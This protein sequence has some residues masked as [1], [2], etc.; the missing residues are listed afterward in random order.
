MI[1]FL[2]HKQIYN[3]KLPLMKIRQTSQ[4]EKFPNLKFCIYQRYT[5]RMKLAKKNITQHQSRQNPK[6]PLIMVK[7]SR[8]K[9]IFQN[10]GCGTSQN[11]VY[12]YML[13][14]N[15]GPV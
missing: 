8:S 10:Y 14:V 11:H 1:R 15:D 4:K 6:W 2:R 3:D 7:D 13:G 5:N 9:I 12:I